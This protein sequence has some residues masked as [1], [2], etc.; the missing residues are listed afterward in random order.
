MLGERT[1]RSLP[2]VWKCASKLLAGKSIIEIVD[3]R[4][5]DDATGRSKFFGHD[6]RLP[7]SPPSLIERQR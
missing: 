4:V 1:G 2:F 6:Q 7:E 3:H 5:K